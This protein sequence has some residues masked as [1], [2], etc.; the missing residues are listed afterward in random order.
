[1]NSDISLAYGKYTSIQNRIRL[2]PDMPDG[3]FWQVPMYETKHIV[4]AD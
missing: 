2:M 4:I 1:M 3:K